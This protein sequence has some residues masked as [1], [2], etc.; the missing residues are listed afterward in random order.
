MADFSFLKNALTK[1]WVVLAPRRAR[2]P[3]IE[4]GKVPVCPFCNNHEEAIYQIPNPKI[5]D[6]K[7]ED[8][9]VKVLPN[10]YP[11][12]P[13]HEL[14]IH[15]PDHTKNFESLPISHIE[16]IFKTY[17]HRYNEHAHKG[18]VYIFHNRGREAG[19]SIPHSH[20]Q[21]AVIPDKV[22][23]G[24]TPLKS[25]ISPRGVFDLEGAKRP[26]SL[27]AGKVGSHRDSIAALQNDSLE[28]EHFMIFCPE[29]SEWPDEVWVA[30]KNGGKTYG[31]IT[32]DEINDLSDILFSLVTIFEHRYNHHFPFNFYISPDDDWYLRLIPRKKILGG[33]EVGTGVMVNTQDPKETMHFIK[34]HFHTPDIEKI[35]KE[36]TT[37]YHH[38]V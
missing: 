8:W 20:T 23:L 3:G 38:S 10:E 36:H 11:F 29:T 26:T 16:L 19:E 25:V 17:R 1:K 21:I 24:I 35:L 13:I 12:A 22:Y 7:N 2:R 33:F 37:D 30:P 32:D 31:A 9:I 5:Q 6:P 18:Q 34:T 14:V 4:Q 28:T 27:P 15:S